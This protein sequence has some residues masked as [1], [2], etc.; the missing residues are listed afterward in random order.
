MLSMMYS[1]CY[2]HK[3][4]IWSQNNMMQRKYRGIHRRCTALDPCAAQSSGTIKNLMQ[5]YRETI[6]Q[7]LGKNQ[8]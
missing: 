6:P 5:L 4:Q 8:V 2:V 7:L 3:E 1:I